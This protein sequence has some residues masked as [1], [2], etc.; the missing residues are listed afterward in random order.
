MRVTTVSSGGA[1]ALSFGI[2]VD[3]GT[4]SRRRNHGDVRWIRAVRKLFK[5][6]REEEV[7]CS[8]GPAQK[9]EVLQVELVSMVVTSKLSLDLNLPRWFYGQR[10][11]HV[12]V[13]LHR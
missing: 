6:R 3:G 13:V 8:R 12:F 5:Q 7:V 1:H 4:R 9:L 2:A 11:K 10:G